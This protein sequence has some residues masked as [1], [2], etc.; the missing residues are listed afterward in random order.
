MKKLIIAFHKIFQPYYQVSFETGTLY[1]DSFFIGSY[2]EEFYIYLYATPFGKVKVKA[3]YR[4]G[5][6]NIPEERLRAGISMTDKEAVE[7]A[8]AIYFSRWKWLYEWD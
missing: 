4:S 8:K 6:E 2:T 1:Y 7:R 3:K 5:H